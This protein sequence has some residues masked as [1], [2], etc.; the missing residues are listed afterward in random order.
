M[1]LKNYKPL[2][3]I[4]AD[5]D[6]IGIFSACLQDAVAKVAD[7]AYLKSERRFALVANRFVWEEGI[8]KKFGPFTRVRTGIH[9]DDVLSVRSRNLRQDA[10]D[11]VVVLLSIDV[12]S[13]EDG[14][15]FVHLNFAGGGA[16]MLGVEAINGALSDISAPWRTR[17]KPDHAG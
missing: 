15:A 12:E 8:S 13:G 3:L 4:A 14:T 7:M 16:I 1:A 2:R 11:A 6:D 9:F 17:S 10:G 5:Q